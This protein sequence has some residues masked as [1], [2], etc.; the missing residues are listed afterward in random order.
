[1]SNAIP[2]EISRLRCEYRVNPMGIDAKRPRFDWLLKSSVRGQKQTAYQILVASSPELLKR[3]EGDL[4]DSGKVASEETCQI[5][6]AGRPLSSRMQ[7]YWKV[8][9]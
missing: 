8:R 2:I 1:M 4:W 9:V 3:E 7:C 6:Y 5:E